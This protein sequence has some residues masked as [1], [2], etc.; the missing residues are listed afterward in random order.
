MKS[1]VVLFE[2]SEDYGIKS[3]DCGRFGCI[4]SD[5][6]KVDGRLLA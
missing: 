5:K 3:S 4:Y 1:V 6:Y 2:I